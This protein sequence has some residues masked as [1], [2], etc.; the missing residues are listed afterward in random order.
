MTSQSGYQTFTIHILNNNS[1]SKNNQ[2][3]KFGHLIEYNRKKIFLEKFCR[4]WHWETRSRPLFIFKK[5]LKGCKS[6]QSAA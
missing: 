1:Q 4:K 6:R 5:C 2:T 3:M